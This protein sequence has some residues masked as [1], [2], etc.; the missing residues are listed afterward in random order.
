MKNIL[1]FILDSNQIQGNF[2]KYSLSSS[3]F[4]KVIIF[5]TAEECLHS[6][7]KTNH[8][9][10]IIADTTLKGTTD[11]E[12]LKLVKSIDPSIQVI[13]YSDNEDISH[14][15]RL[16]DAGATDYIVRIEG[17]R[18]W[19]RELTSNLQYLIKEEFRPR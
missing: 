11:L 8:P 6:I 18:N 4:K 10:F 19:I 2:L 9:D 12:F 7:R 14:I 3:G 15:A 16:L 5:Q 1:V 13:F 17:N